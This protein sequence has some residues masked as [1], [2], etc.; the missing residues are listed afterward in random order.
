MSC[1]ESALRLSR[2]LVAVCCL[3]SRVVRMGRALETAS[4]RT[5]GALV[6]LWGKSRGFRSP[7]R[8][9]RDFPHHS[10]VLLAQR[11]ADGQFV[12]RGVLR[13]FRSLRR[14]RSG[15]PFLSSGLLVQ[16]KRGNVRV[17]CALV[18]AGN[19]L[20][21]PDQDTIVCPRSGG[22]HRGLCLNR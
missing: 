2:T 18:T 14:L 3:L 19:L 4:R 13:V 9:C 11:T 8:L 7:R 1:S 17:S 5:A 12:Q 21:I 15:F 10:S 16:L 22:W 6:A 20:S